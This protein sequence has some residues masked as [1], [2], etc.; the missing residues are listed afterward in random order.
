[1]FGVIAR[2]YKISLFYQNFNNGISNIVPTVRFDCNNRPL[3]PP[4]STSS[5]KRMRKNKDKAWDSFDLSPSKEYLEYALIKQGVYSNEEFRL[6]YN[7]KN[8]LTENLKNSCKGSYCYLRNKCKLKSGVPS[9]E[10]PDGSYTMTAIAVYLLRSPWD[11][12]Q[13]LYKMALDLLMPLLIYLESALT[14]GHSLKCG[15]QPMSLHFL[16]VAPRNCHPI[17]GQFP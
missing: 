11:L 14:W 13:S 7:Y 2:K 9:L 17:I 15:R 5:F 8:K 16:R 10:E 6:K 4:W 3:K 12:F 1:M